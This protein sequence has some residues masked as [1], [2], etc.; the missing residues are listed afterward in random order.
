MTTQQAMDLTC[1]LAAN[2]NHNPPG[3]KI[4]KVLTLY[5]VKSMSQ[6]VTNPDS[7]IYLSFSGNK[8]VKI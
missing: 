1:H 7:E 6:F 5:F 2:I 4:F 8:I 3:K